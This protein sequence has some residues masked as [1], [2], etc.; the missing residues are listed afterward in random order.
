[1]SQIV[2]RRII[3]QLGGREADSRRYAADRHSASEAVPGRHS[4]LALVRGVRARFPY[5]KR[6]GQ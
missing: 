2:L 5:E 3:F 4:T 1:M 6:A